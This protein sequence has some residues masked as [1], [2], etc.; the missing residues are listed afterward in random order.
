M[1]MAQNEIRKKQAVEVMGLL[2][3]AIDKLNPLKDN[4]GGV[5]IGDEATQ[6]QYNS[7]QDRL[8][9]VVIELAS[10]FDVD[11]EAFGWS[12]GQKVGLP[13]SITRKTN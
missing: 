7:M 8:A 11:L 6:E 5:W 1:G 10:D 3:Q 4:R 9:A 12:I 13:S 2:D